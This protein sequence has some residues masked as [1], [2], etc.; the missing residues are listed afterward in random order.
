MLDF[1]EH[2]LVRYVVFLLLTAVSAIVPFYKRARIHGFQ[3]TWR[4]VKG[5]TLT[6]GIFVIPG[7]IAVVFSGIEAIFNV[8]IPSLLIGAVALF[9]CSIFWRWVK[10][11]GSLEPATGGPKMAQVG[12]PK[13]IKP[14]WI[15]T[16][17]WLALGLFFISN[18]RNI[19][20]EASLQ[21]YIVME[22]DCNL[23][24]DLLDHRYRCVARSP[25]NEAPVDSDMWC[26]SSNIVSFSSRRGFGTKT[27][28]RCRVIVQ[29]PKK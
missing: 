14:K 21:T 22:N 5:P 3:E 19:F 15:R 4:N 7:I 29:T 6:L 2:M 26:H 13:R 12:E 24:R 23:R 9:N 17:G 8:H 20:W 25:P 27:R 10:E 18:T 11:E 1:L 16:C 28:Q